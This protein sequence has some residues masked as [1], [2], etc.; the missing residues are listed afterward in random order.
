MKPISLD[1]RVRIIESHD[2]GLTSQRIADQYGVGIATVKRLIQLRRQSGSLEAGKSTG[3]TPILDETA[4]SLMQEWLHEKNDLTLGELQ[5]RL[6]ES[7]FDVC[8]SA[9]CRRLKSMG[10]TTKKKRCVRPNKTETM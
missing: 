1:L 10:L 3:R 7:G 5:E 9:I 2:L 8:V 4:C 6:K